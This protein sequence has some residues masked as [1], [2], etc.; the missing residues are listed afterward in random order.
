MWENHKS[1]S[2]RGIEVLHKEFNYMINRKIK[3]TKENHIMPTRQSKNWKTHWIGRPDAVMVNSLA[4]V[5]P[6]PYFRKV[7]E[8][9]FLKKASVRICGLGF[10][11][12][13]LN[14]LKVGDHV[15]DPV[16]SQYDKRVRYVEYDVKEY[17]HP[18]ENV[19]GVILGNGWYNCHTAT[20][21]HFDKATWRDYPKLTLELNMDNEL[22]LQSDDSWKVADGPIVFD[23]LRNGES[24]DARLELKDWLSLNYDDSQWKTSAY[25]HPPGGILEQQTMPACK[26]TKTIEPVNSWTLDNGD[27][28]FDIGQ[29]MTGWARIFVSGKSGDEV[30]I[31]YGE[32]LN[33]RALDQ[34]KISYLI[35]SGDCQ[36]DR[37]ILKGEGEES[38]EPRFTYHGF[39][40]VQISTTADIQKIEGRVVNTA[41]EQSGEFSCSNETLNKLHKNTIWS[42]IGNF[43]GIP[44]DCPHREKNGW[45][46]DAQL[47]AETGL[48]NFDSGSSYN[49]WIDS[50]SD[51]QRPS[52][53]LPGIVPSTGWGYNWGSGPAWDSAFILIPWYIY[54]YSGDSSAIN[55]NYDAIKKYVDYL[56]YMAVDH[57]VSIGL[58]DWCHVDKERIVD[59]SVTSTAYY[60]MDAVLLSKFAVMTGH[61]EDAKYYSEL[62]SDIRKTFNHK[63]YMGEGIYANGEPTAL[64]CA[65]Y[66][67][68]VED[69]EKAKVIAKLVETLEKNN[70]KA[71]FGIL[72]AKYIPR[73]LSDNGHA[74]LA[75]KLIT[76]PEF[77][78]W[79]HWLKQGATT[80]WEDW[81]GESSRNHIMFGDISAW[82]YQ[83]LAGIIP[84]PK[85]PGF[86][87]FIIKP[88]PVDGVEWVKAEHKLS[89]G[90]I[91]V[92]WEKLDSKFELDVKIPED[93]NATIVMPDQSSYNLLAGKHHLSSCL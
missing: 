92:S 70:Y 49:H 12:L 21:W 24:Y 18:G 67:G 5:L 75:Y 20:A 59:V 83:Y 16:V 25:A 11:E 86:K 81:N 77:P 69:S 10:Y 36:T 65:V 31:R 14:G 1:G 62:A 39:Q 45:T 3:Q 84:N 93:S 17:L 4:K 63:F 35:K 78:G 32:R 41:F 91:Q 79:A 57:I 85:A 64:A 48:F 22:I 47:A 43:T 60:Y 82:M 51:V 23:G 87:S 6:A 58:G 71:D 66:Q 30:T 76:Q 40:Y 15:L 8:L 80:L 26:V 29:N 88:N 28:V 9:N 61:A 37:Y 90:S 27:T 7:F 38:W 44:T 73:V 2:V 55:K 34:E 50:I 54:V 89:S 42:Y 52:G 13:Y 46:G 19:I 33:D 68:L 53:Q 56:S 74:E 72:G